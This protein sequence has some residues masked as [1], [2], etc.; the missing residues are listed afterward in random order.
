M[1]EPSSLYRYARAEPNRDHILAALYAR[2]DLT[3]NFALQPV[4]FEH[5]PSLA[6]GSAAILTT[7]VLSGQAVVDALGRVQPLLPGLSVR[8]Q[9][10]TPIIYDGSPAGLPR[11]NWWSP[12]PFGPP[13]AGAPASPDGDDLPALRHRP[14]ARICPPAARHRRPHRQLQRARCKYHRVDWPVPGDLDPQYA[15][16]FWPPLPRHQLGSLSAAQ[17]AASDQAA[18]SPLG[19]GP[20]V[21]QSWQ[22]GQSIT[23]FKRNPNY[24]RAAEGLPHFDQVTYR[25]LAGPNDL[26]AGLRDGSGDVTPSGLAMDSAGWPDDRR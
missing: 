4:L 20:F 13:C 9:D 22:P 24:W 11:P 2:P 15:V 8:Q 18:K 16:N 10:G 23:S 21:F 3:A 17:I 7:R 14:A 12:S 26:A 25:F 1:G 6:E 5:L 19:W